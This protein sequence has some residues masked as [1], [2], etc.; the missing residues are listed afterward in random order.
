VCIYQQNEKLIYSFSK[1]I[2]R[3]EFNSLTER[4]N[5]KVNCVKNEKQEYNFQLQ[6]DDIKSVRVMFTRS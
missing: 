4:H 5:E 6:A 1:K 2:L 3:L